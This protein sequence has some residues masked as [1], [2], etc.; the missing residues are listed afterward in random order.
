MRALWTLLLSLLLAAPMVADQK[1]P[2]SVQA[3]PTLGKKTPEFTGYD[4]KGKPI[5]L[6]QYTGKIVVLE[7]TNKDCPFVKKYYATGAM[8]RLQQEA[9]EK[10]IVWISIVSSAPGKQGHLTQTGISEWK[11]A[12]KAGPEA[13]IIDETGEIGRRYG[14]KTTPHMF[15]IAADG[16]LVYAGAID[17]IA[18][19]NTEDI[20][21]AT[22]YVANT[23]RSLTAG[24]SVTP[25]KTAP[26]GCSVK[27]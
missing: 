9:K 12:T 20:T 7:W 5:S 6:S 22:P 14:A 13:V 16:T 15:V 2:T 1:N 23:L 19:T 26:Y 8:Q 24:K 18:S 27:Y 25:F 21:K 11:T 3:P 4:A 10:G 17:S